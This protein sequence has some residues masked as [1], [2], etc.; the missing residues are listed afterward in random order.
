MAPSIAT[1]G[2]GGPVL[3]LRAGGSLLLLSGGWGVV[4]LQR[5]ELSPVQYRMTFTRGQRSPGPSLT[6]EPSGGMGRRAGAQ[7]SQWDPHFT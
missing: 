7:N 4:L 5:R 6:L 3:L 2:Q 1:K